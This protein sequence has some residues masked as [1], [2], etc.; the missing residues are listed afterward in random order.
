MKTFTKKILSL[1]NLEVK[2][3]NPNYRSVESTNTYFG[4]LA[5]T[6]SDHKI[7]L[8]LDVGASTGNWA[9]QLMDEGYNS[10]IVSFEPLSGSYRVLKSRCSEFPNWECQNFAL[11]NEIGQTSINVSKNNESSSLSKILNSHID[12]FPESKIIREENIQLK[13]IDNFLQNRSDL[14]GNIFA[15]LDV[16]GFE[17]K[18]LTGA[19]GS[20]NRISILQLEMGLEAL[21]DDEFLFCDWLKH[22]KT[23]HFHPLHIQNAFSHHETKRLLQVDCIFLNE[24]MVK[25]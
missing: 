1:F 14:Q 15:K 23:L 24:K 20:L 5:K 16:Q 22:L 6:L 8:T 21:Y 18:V 19:S 11:G 17:K 13:T 10:K 12:A 9:S 4:F 25:L 3:V 2:K 7:N